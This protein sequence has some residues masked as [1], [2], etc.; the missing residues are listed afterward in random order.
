MGYE[1]DREGCIVRYDETFSQ[2]GLNTMWSRPL[3][4]LDLT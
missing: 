2:Y 3:I 4:I 1:T